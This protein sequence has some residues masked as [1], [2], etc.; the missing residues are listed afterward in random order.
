MKR[1]SYSA[2]LIAIFLFAVISIRAQQADSLLPGVWKGTSICQVKNS[3]CHDEVVVYHIS[4]GKELH[5]YNIDAYK[6]VNGKEEDMGTLH[7]IVDEKKNELT[8]A[9]YGLWTFKL[10]N[11]SLHGT[12]YARNSLYRIIELAKEK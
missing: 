8:S 9:E 2:S 1:K 5:S 12:L 3:P 6:I 4:K 11:D 10:N 7:F